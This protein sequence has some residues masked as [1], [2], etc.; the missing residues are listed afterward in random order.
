MIQRK[1][2]G[3]RILIVL[4]MKRM[5]TVSLQEVLMIMAKSLMMMKMLTQLLMG[6]GHK[7]TSILEKEQ[8]KM[9]SLI[10][11]LE[12]SQNRI[13]T[14]K[15]LRIVFVLPIKIICMTSLW[16]CWVLLKTWNSLVILVLAELVIDL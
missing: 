5:K 10:K 15:L 11:I 3:L 9:I 6:F 12:E 4:K 2:M 8:E 16:L 14:T 13:A 1:R 7:E